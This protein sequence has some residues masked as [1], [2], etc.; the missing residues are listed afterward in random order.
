[1]PTITDP[2]EK[3][4]FLLNQYKIPFKKELVFHPTRKWRFDYGICIWQEEGV[5]IPNRNILIGI[6][7]EGG[8][9]LKTGHVLGNMYTKNCEK[10]NAAATLG[11]YVL[12]YTA[13]MIRKDAHQLIS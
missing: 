7:F 6:E 9:F 10:Y 1:M 12:R 13:P 3:I 8:V 5:G 4:E 11:W 2:K